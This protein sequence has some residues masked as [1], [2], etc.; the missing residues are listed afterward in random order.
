MSFGNGQQALLTYDRAS[1]S[2][3]ELILP[4][5]VVEDTPERT[6]I[7]VTAGTPIRTLLHA[8]GTPVPRDTPYLEVAKM[9]RVLGDSV[10]TSTNVLIC[11]QPEWQWDVRLMWN[12][13]TWEF[14]CWYMNIQDRM[15]RDDSGFSTTDHFIDLVVD[16]RCKWTIKDQH[17]L[18]DAIHLEMYSPTEASAIRAALH[19]AITH[20]ESRGWPFNSSLQDFRPNPHWPIPPLHT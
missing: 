18:D 2:R 13:R 15:R 7:Y 4:A 10:W 11:W 19:G 6:A 17:E 12:A 20:V 8:D 1:P 5:T 9:D 14:T 16:S 3:T